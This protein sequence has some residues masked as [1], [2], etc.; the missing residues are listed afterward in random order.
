M[1]AVDIYRHQTCP[2]YTTFE[3]C[4]SECVYPCMNFQIPEVCARDA[5]MAICARCKNGPTTLTLSIHA[6]CTDSIPSYHHQVITLYYT[7]L[8]SPC[9]A[10]YI[11][12]CL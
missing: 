2:Q 7:F 1:P 3:C 6:A 4:R 5:E 8:Y 11:G 12:P 10:H 9:Y